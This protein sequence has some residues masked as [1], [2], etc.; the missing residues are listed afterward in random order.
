MNFFLFTAHMSPNDLAS[1]M[2]NIDTDVNLVG[3]VTTIKSEIWKREYSS[4]PIWDYNNFLT[5]V[6][7]QSQETEL[8]KHYETLIKNILSDQRVFY[9]AENE[10]QRHGFGSM[11]NAIKIIDTIC[12]NSISVINDVSPDKIVL[13]STPHSIREFV[14]C[15][16]AEYLGVEVYFT[17]NRHS[18]IPWKVTVI[19]GIDMQEW[20][21]LESDNGVMLISEKGKKHLKMIRSTYDEAIPDYELRRKKRYRNIRHIL[22]SE[23]KNLFS[24]YGV[25]FPFRLKRLVLKTASYRAYKSHSSEYLPEH[26]FMVLF[27]HFQPERTSNP[28]GLMYANQWLAA[29]KLSQVLSKRGISLVVKEHPSTY[30]NHFS[31]IWRDVSFYQGLVALPNTSLAFLDVDPFALIDKSIAVAT[32]T[33]TVGFES[34]VRGRPTICF[35]RANYKGITG[36]RF[37]ENKKDIEDAVDDI[38]SGVLS[39][40][41]RD[42]NKYFSELEANSFDEYDERINTSL[43]AIQFAIKHPCCSGLTNLDTKIA[44]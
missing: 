32:L 40:N 31:T 9:M 15:K 20:V 11:T 36:C 3:M 41:D 44:L 1:V 29:R 13:N 34:I 26:K 37:V 42:T 6:R 2:D 33:G 39:A 19:K 21:K 28:E 43:K 35:G 38:L 27:L 23:L 18:T 24:N 17:S 8:H 12:W 16:V 22:I 5:D 14:F 4:L 10:F 30:R 25:Y 7:E